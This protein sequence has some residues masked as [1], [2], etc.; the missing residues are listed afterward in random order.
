MK[1]T[2][3]TLKNLVSKRKSCTY[4]SYFLPLDTVSIVPSVCVTASVTPSSPFL[5]GSSFTIQCT[6]QYNIEP[7]VNLY[8]TH[9]AEDG[10]YSELDSLSLSSCEGLHQTKI[11]SY[12]IDN[13]LHLTSDGNYSCNFSGVVDTV[14][15]S[16]LEIGKMILSTP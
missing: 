13:A 1:N 3:L 6:I 16:V 15:V 14:A 12:S 2:K 5:P 9:L 10:L 7:G 4:V 8:I 11:C